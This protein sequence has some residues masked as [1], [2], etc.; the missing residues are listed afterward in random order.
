[1]EPLYKGFKDFLDFYVNYGWKENSSQ[2][3]KDA[4]DAMSRVHNHVCWLNPTDTTMSRRTRRLCKKFCKK[5]NIPKEPYFPKEYCCDHCPNL[6]TVYK[7][8]DTFLFGFGNSWVA[9]KQGKIEI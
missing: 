9:E 2:E 1:M 5:N 4:S 8:G 6:I 7:D 3:E